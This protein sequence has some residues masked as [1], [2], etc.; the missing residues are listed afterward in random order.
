MQAA[1]PLAI[2][3]SLIKGVAGFQAGRYNAAVQR[4]QAN[5]ELQIGS[6]E[7]LAARDAARRVMEQQL[8]RMAES[9]FTVGDGSARAALEE[10]LIAREVDVMQARRT[11]AGRAAG[12]RSSARLSLRRG[13]FDLLEG[14]V[15]AAGIVANHRVDM[16]AAGS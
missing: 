8:G 9:G 1:L 13:A 12:L 10:S 7:A 15:G 3:G 16:A 5:E 14:A 4:A 6:A 2:G 11:A